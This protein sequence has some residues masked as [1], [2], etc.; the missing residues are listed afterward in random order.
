ML[1]YRLA[2]TLGSSEG[3]ITESEQVQPIIIE[4]LRPP[5]LFTP[6]SGTTALGSGWSL[7]GTGS[8]SARLGWQG[9]EAL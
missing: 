6:S 4:A 3:D 1:A 9:T 5:Q 8:G 7:V 2:V